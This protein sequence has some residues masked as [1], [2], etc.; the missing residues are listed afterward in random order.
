MIGRATQ[1]APSPLQEVAELVGQSG[2]FIIDTILCTRRLLKDICR[3]CIG[4]CGRDLGCAAAAAMYESASNEA[5]ITPFRQGGLRERNE[6][7]EIAHVELVQN[8]QQW[9]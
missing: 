5:K 2:G 9:G 3:N 6:S 8:V 7:I 1:S 4:R